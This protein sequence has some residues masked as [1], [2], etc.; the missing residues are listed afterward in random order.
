MTPHSR[1]LPNGIAIP[2]NV[3][4]DAR[5]EK[6]KEPL[7]NIKHGGKFVTVPEEP[8]STGAAPRRYHTACFTCRV[9]GEVFEEKEGGHAVF[10][11]VEEGACHVRVSSIFIQ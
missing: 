1:V 7:F 11:R 9:C 8:T 5:C 3:P 10:V 6:C 2:E 4:S